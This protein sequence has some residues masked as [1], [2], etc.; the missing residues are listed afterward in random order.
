[1]KLPL[2]RNA[3]TESSRRG[4]AAFRMSIGLAL[5]VLAFS[6][7]A[8]TLL[9][10]AQEAITSI[11]Q[12][13]E[14]AQD[15]DTIVIMPGEY[16]D[17]VAVWRQKKLTI[18]GNDPRPTLIADGRTAE[19]KAIWVIRDGDFTVENIE[20][21]GAR[22]TDGNGAGIRFERGRLEVI[23]CRFSDNQN[24]ILTGNDD[25][26]QLTI[27]DS[28]FSS[29]PA[30]TDSLPHL[31]YAGK[32]GRLEISGSRFHNGHVG[33]LI[34]SRARESVLRYNL[35]FDGEGGT[36]SYELDLPNGGDVLLVGNIIGQ[37]RDTENPV[38]IAYGAEGGAWPEN[39]LRMSHNTLLSESLMGGWFLRVWQDRIP[40]GA[41]VYGINNLTV[42][43]G[44]FT[45]AASG[46]FNGNIPLPPGVLRPD[47]LDFSLDDE[48]LLRGWVDPLP[49]GDPMRPTAEFSLPIGTRPLPALADWVPGA[50]QTNL[51]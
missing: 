29:A 26:A 20:F 2:W 7:T 19:N 35:I 12:A 21:R 25:R 17:D 51:Y 9:V 13:V 47:V 8:D 43:L 39:R 38:V 6:V 49:E 28:L 15:G 31:L 40:G 24:G 23:R 37:S 22:S 27:T 4:H 46:D 41:S 36:A 1:M 10:G 42:G 11:A 44:L 14:L 3:R 50:R 45:L 48:S 5:S 30:Q 33:H 34:K 16:R 18:I 32:I